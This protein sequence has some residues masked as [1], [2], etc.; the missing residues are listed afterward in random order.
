MRIRQSSHGF[1][2]LDTVF[3]LLIL[4]GTSAIAAW[5]LASTYQQSNELSAMAALRLIA[6]TQKDFK[7]QTF[8]YGSLEEL[9][10][11]ATPNGDS[12]AFK[13]LLPK[14][15]RPGKDPYILYKGYL[16]RVYL[17]LEETGSLASTEKPTKAPAARERWCAY[18]WPLQY[19]WTGRRAFFI[20]ESG[21]VYAAFNSE[22]SGKNPKKLDAATAFQQR[23][24]FTEIDASQW[25]PASAP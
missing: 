11:S 21:I 6:A 14:D 16:F 15:F 5:N 23:Q 8:E 24:A 12:K 25:I 7:N 20:S 3:F 2:T 4:A 17:P 18:A 22:L 9:T 19:A 1:T 13:S 10:G